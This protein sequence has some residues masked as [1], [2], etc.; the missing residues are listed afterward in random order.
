M[1][2]AETD[3]VTPAAGTASRPRREKDRVDSFAHRHIGPD[4]E[5][6]AAMLAEVGFANLDELID[7]TVPK[8][9]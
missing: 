1:P 2:T 7:A 3:V 5:A 9:I 8:N 4:E 6:R